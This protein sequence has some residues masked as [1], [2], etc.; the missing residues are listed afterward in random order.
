MK[1]YQSKIIRNSFFVIIFSN[2]SNV[3]SF[4]YQIIIGRNISSSEYGL[5]ISFYSALAILSIPAAVIPF[6]V[7]N[8]FN[9]KETLKEKNYFLA[10][11]FYLCGY[12]LIFEIISVFFFY[13]IFFALLKFESLSYLIF[14]LSLQFLTLIMAILMGLYTSKSMYVNYSLIGPSSLY[15]RLILLIICIF[16][17]TVINIDLILKINI[18]SIFISILIALYFSN[19]ELLKIFFQKYE[20]KNGIIK[21]I[22]F[23]IPAL[24]VFIN[25]IFLQNIDA[26]LIRRILSESDSGVIAPMIVLGRIP[27]FIFSALIYVIFPEVKKNF[28]IIKN[29][30]SFKKFLFFLLIIIS[31][32][33]F[34][35][36]FIYLFGQ[37]IINLI[38]NKNFTN[39]NF[40]FLLITIYYFQV[41]LFLI[42]STL[43]L[44][45]FTKK[46]LFS[47]ILIFL[48]IVI[49]CTLSFLYLERAETLFILLNIMIFIINIISFYSSFNFFIKK[50]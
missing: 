6:I 1:I 10:N 7:N 18:L 19:T 22:K 28:Y 2:L 30:F 21:I 15:F 9:G 38:F 13:N 40:I 16:F 24:F 12:I 4:F 44:T 35:C 41:F 37:E 3:A 26:I 49:F 11:I 34:Y 46:L 5:L 32:F 39:I 20:F 25:V 8:F 45:F 48:V 33:A 50:K 36:F 23:S 43:F 47:Y 17:F 42:S 14:L 31:T 29:S 27:I